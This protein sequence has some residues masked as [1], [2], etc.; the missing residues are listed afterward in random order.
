M[1]GKPYRPYQGRRWG[2]MLLWV[3]VLVL[4]ASAVTFLAAPFSIRKFAAFPALGGLFLILF[5]L[6]ARCPAGRG[7]TLRRALTILL[8][9]GVAGFGVLEG[10]ILAGARTEI[11]GEPRMMVI[12]GCQVQSWGPSVLLRDRLDTALA[13]LEEHPELPVVVTGGQ[14][15][16]EPTTEAAAM[17]D[18]LVE[19]GVEES[20]I[21]LEE[22]SHNTWQNINNTFALLKEKG[23]GE[24]MGQVLVVTNG[25]HLARVRILWARVWEGTYTLST[26]AAPESH[27]GAR[28]QSY[29]REAPA[30]V[31]SWLLDRN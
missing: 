24:R 26:L 18:Y 28:V 3:G 17:R 6:T 19:H 7:R 5:A 11:K 15:P 25:F 2:E 9:L 1:R 12:L 27:M 29:L 21:L 22:A 30:L 8:C 20:R 31:K 23:Y 10:V 13:Y 14:G 16:D 4:A